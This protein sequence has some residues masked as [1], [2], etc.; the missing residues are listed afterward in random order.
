MLTIKRTNG[1][2]L[3]ARML[4]VRCILVVFALSICIWLPTVGFA[5]QSTQ[6]SISL[7]ALESRSIDPGEFCTLVCRVRNN[8]SVDAEYLVEVTVPPGWKTTGAASQLRLEPGSERPVF[9]TFCAPDTEPA[10]E[11]PVTFAVVDVLTGEVIVEATTS[12][13]VNAVYGVRIDAEVF[14]I[15]LDSSAPGQGRLGIGNL[16]N[17]VDTYTV[18]V[19][20]GSEWTVTGL[21]DSVTLEVAESVSIEFEV[22]ASDIGSAGEGLLVVMVSSDH[23]SRAAACSYKLRPVHIVGDHSW[24]EYGWQIP[25]EASLYAVARQSTDS[26]RVSGRVSAS[27]RYYDRFALAIGLASSDLRNG[28]TSYYLKYEDEMKALGLGHVGQ[29]LGPL[30]SMSG[31]GLSWLFRLGDGALSGFVGRREGEARAGVGVSYDLSSSSWV[32]GAA[33]YYDKGGVTSRRLGFEVGTTLGDRLA[34]SARVVHSS[35]GDTTGGLSAT[36]SARASYPSS[37]LRG[38][39]TLTEASYVGESSDRA[40]VRVDAEGSLSDS[41][42]AGISLSAARNNI[43]QEETLPSIAYLGAT[44]RGRA[45][46]LGMIVSASVGASQQVDL[47]SD[48][49]TADTARASIGTS[50]S[51]DKVSLWLQAENEVRRDL[52]AGQIAHMQS[53]SAHLRYSTPT[54]SSWVFGHLASSPDAVSEGEPLSRA[55]IGLMYSP[56]TSPVSLWTTW[57]EEVPIADSTVQAPRSEIGIG[58]MY[59]TSRWKWYLSGTQFRTSPEAETCSTSLTLGVSYLLAQDLEIG[60]DVTKSWPASGRE[61]LVYGLS[62]TKRFALPIPGIQAYAL[63]EGVAYLDLD[64]DGVWDEDDLTVPGVVMKLDAVRARTNDEGRFA[65]PPLEP[66][67]YTLTVESVPEGLECTTPMPREVHVSSDETVRIEVRFAEVSSISG[68]VQHSADGTIDATNTGVAR[69]VVVAIGQEES[70]RTVTNS[71]GRYYLKVP[72][73]EYSVTLDVGSL[74]ARY[75]LSTASHIKVTLSK[76]EREQVDFG[77]A[78]RAREIVF[79]SGVSAEAKPPVISVSSVQESAQPGEIAHLVVS[80]DQKLISVVARIRGVE[81]LPEVSFSPTDGGMTWSGPLYVPDVP[82]DACVIEIVVRDSRGKSWTSQYDTR[83]V[84][85]Q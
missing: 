56:P 55:G 62:L 34:L 25:A 60:L 3:S 49:V 23:L 54:W 50:C 38:Q 85:I 2:L 36:A 65:F 74:P 51:I 69:V 68:M 26:V 72:P 63:I 4:V 41:L 9:I 18:E 15:C 39:L 80:S 30:G 78:P 31:V 21:P 10:G 35:S 45:T 40:E 13:T 71:E 64:S 48:H 76:G 37:F 46:L 59:R 75:A 1:S 67:S 73:G 70:Y 84:Q 17:T 66:G 5:G 7:I 27:G 83:L 61:D 42:Y 79:T 19:R 20:H 82:A 47:S 24:R 12:V 8:R 32:A 58:G 22:A 43:A 44:V 11:Y 33:G 6:D 29:R 28:I 57:R 53:Y 77:I 52:V 81:G 14:V 16:G